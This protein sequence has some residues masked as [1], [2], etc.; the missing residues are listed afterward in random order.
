ML[1]HCMHYKSCLDT[2]RIFLTEK[3]ID[4]TKY[5]TLR[6]TSFKKNCTLLFCPRNIFVHLHFHFVKF[7]WGFLS[8]NISISIREIYDFGIGKIQCTRNRSQHIFQTIWIKTLTA[9]CLFHK[10]KH[11]ALSKINSSHWISP[12]SIS[13]FVNLSAFLSLLKLFPFCFFFWVF[14]FFFCSQHKKD[15]NVIHF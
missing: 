12:L 3:T 15:W 2:T 13:V 14:F 6:L 5:I 4:M 1:V 9:L 10:K 11:F 8:L 7:C